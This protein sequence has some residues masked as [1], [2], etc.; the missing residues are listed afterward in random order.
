M[1]IINKDIIIKAP[2]EALFNFTSKPVNLTQIWPGLVELKNMKSLSNG[3]FSFQWVYKMSGT[4]FS[5]SG[6]CVDIMPYHWFTSRMIGGIESNN[7]WT[8]RAK[9][10]KT[11][12]TFT[13]DYKVPLVLSG[14]VDVDT[15]NN[16]NERESELLLEN[17]RTLFENKNEVHPVVVREQ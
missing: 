14:R 8:F 1:P 12:V 17:L 2:P 15:L 3:G 6:E 4:N 13:M 5:G 9:R 16:M 11:R 10:D 7:T